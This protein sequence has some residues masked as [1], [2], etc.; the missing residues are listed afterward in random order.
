MFISYLYDRMEAAGSF[1]FMFLLVAK[2]TYVD[3]FQMLAWNQGRLISLPA[4]FKQISKGVADDVKNQL[5]TYHVAMNVHTL[6]SFSK[7][8]NDGFSSVKQR[9]MI[10]SWAVLLWSCNRRKMGVR[11]VI[12]GIQSKIYQNETIFNH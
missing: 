9:S 7:V 5:Q 6:T 12:E 4:N 8:N 2:D 10:L 1:K 3:N 11:E